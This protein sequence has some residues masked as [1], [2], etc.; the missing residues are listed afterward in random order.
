MEG[1]IYVWTYPSHMNAM[2]KCKTGT[3]NK[4]KV[5]KLCKPT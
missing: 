1:L 4:T 5:P 3:R 2:F